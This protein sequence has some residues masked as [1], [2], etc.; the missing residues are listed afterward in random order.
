MG[1]LSLSIGSD[2]FA[3]LALGF[4]TALD[5]K[6]GGMYMVSVTYEISFQGH[7][8]KFELADVIIIDNSLRAPT[9]PT[10]LAAGLL[11][12]SRPAQNDG[13]AVESIQ[14]SWDR[15]ERPENMPNQK[16]ITLHPASYAVGRFGPLDRQA[17]ILLEPRPSGGWL[18]FA[19]SR[20]KTEKKVSFI[21]HLVRKTTIGNPVVQIIGDPLP[22]DLTYA[23]AAQDLFGRW[24]GWQTVD[25]SLH[26]AQ[27]SPAIV[28]AI[29]DPSGALR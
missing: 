17:E 6:P 8:F 23:V 27:T 25:T 4:G 19:A 1:L 7:D 11:S 20:P 24:T 28:G 12:H 10:G 2:P 26:G 22:V 16:I 13:P 29:L 14:A 5:G 3:S 15:P 21:D 18:P 9:A